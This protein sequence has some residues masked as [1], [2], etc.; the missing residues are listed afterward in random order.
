MAERFDKL[1]SFFTLTI[2]QVQPNEDEVATTNQKAVNI[3]QSFANRF[4]LAE[5]EKNDPANRLS[6][7]NEELSE[8]KEALPIIKPRA[9]DDANLIGG[10]RHRLS[11]RLLVLRV[12]AEKV[13][14]KRASL[15]LIDGAIPED[16]IVEGLESIK[17]ILPSAAI[18]EMQA[19]CLVD[20][21]IILA[22]T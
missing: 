10:R 5:Q 21:N 1:P 4:H 15:I 12:V 9:E 8:A 2:T 16:A 19:L 18:D 14:N 7:A 11:S 6:R 22:E 13:A 17:S 3:I 20:D